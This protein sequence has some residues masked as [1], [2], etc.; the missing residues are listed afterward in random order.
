MTIETE[1]IAAWHAGTP[2]NDL[3][4]Q[5]VAETKSRAAGL[6]R[7]EDNELV[8]CGFGNVPD[9]TDDVIQG[10]KDVT[11]RVT[12]DKTNLGIVRAIVTDKPTIARLDPSIS[13]LTGSASWLVRFDCVSSLAL[14]IHDSQTKAQIGA[15][16]ISTTD[17]IQE[18]DATWQMMLRIANSLGDRHQIPA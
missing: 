16:A 7:M 8:M 9:M 11:G 10:F 15:V 18:E 17:D 13:G 2:L 5:F 6:W 3:L 4:T 1:L 14:P 12:L